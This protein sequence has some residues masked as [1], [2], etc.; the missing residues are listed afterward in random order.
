MAREHVNN[1]ALIGLRM[2]DIEVIRLRTG[3]RGLLS[4]FLLQL[5][6]TGLYCIKIVTDTHDLGYSLCQIRVI[7]CHLRSKFDRPLFAVNM[8]AMS[9]RYVPGATAI[10][11]AV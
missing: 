4:Q 9:F 10:K 7:A 8:A 6:L 2:S 3:G 1:P 5:R 11:P